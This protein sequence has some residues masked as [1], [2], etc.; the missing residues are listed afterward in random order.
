MF[1]Q[2][3]LTSRVSKGCPVVPLSRD[4][5]VSLSHCPLVPGQK[6]F[7]VWLSLCPGT[8][9]AAIIPGQDPLFQDVPWKDLVFCFAHFSGKKMKLD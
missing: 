9:A 3:D 4:K 5:K 2:K 8:R 6:S 1:H 7:L